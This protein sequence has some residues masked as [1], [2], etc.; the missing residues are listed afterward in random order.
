MINCIISLRLYSL[1]YCF[2]LMLY[3][4]MVINLCSFN[5]EV[6]STYHFTTRNLKA[7]SLNTIIFIL[8]LIDF[9]LSSS[10]ISDFKW[11]IINI[12]IVYIWH[13]DIISSLIICDIWLHIEKA[14]R[15]SLSMKR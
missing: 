8:I 3:M 12:I 4:L 13:I 5:R 1:L 9:I 11:I 10:K 7:V 6:L 14:V 2:I 15:S